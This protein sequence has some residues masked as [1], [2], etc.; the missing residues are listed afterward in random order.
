MCCLC[1]CF[2]PT[3]SCLCLAR[4]F[5]HGAFNMP[6]S[7]WSATYIIWIFIPLFSLVASSDHSDCDC[8]GCAI[9]S[10]GREGYIYATDRLV[11]LET[12]TWPFKGDRCPSLIGKPKLFFIQVTP[13][14]T[15]WSNDIP[16]IFSIFVIVKRVSSVFL[17]VIPHMNVRIL[18][19]LLS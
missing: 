19:I 9:L 15:H 2:M 13:F 6:Q 18:A 1:I 8:F 12:L 16:F 3:V 10:H 11:P 14:T 7:S 17:I 4:S 5:C